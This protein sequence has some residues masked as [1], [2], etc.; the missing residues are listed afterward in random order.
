[1]E[2]PI[3]GQWHQKLQLQKMWAQLI[4]K[5]TYLIIGESSKPL[6][7]DAPRSCAS[8]KGGGGGVFLQGGPHFPQQI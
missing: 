3:R 1:M 6:C 7:H 8:A 2:F 4:L 5:Q